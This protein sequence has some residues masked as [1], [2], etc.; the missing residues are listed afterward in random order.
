MSARREERV[1]RLVYVRD[2][3]LGSMPFHKLIAARKDWL[4][5]IL[6]LTATLV[7]DDGDRAGM[8]HEVW[9]QG[10]ECLLLGVASDERLKRL[11]DFERVFTRHAFLL[12]CDGIEVLVDGF[13]DLSTNVRLGGC[14]TGKDSACAQSKECTE[15]E[16]EMHFFKRKTLGKTKEIRKF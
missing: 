16:S 14:W 1:V 10:C 4:S 6:W 8:V 11:C 2:G 12:V 5:E 15:A 3:L 7:D 13:A 9:R